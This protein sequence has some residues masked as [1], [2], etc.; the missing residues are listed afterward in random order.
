MRA[1]QV[2]LLEFS[3]SLTLSR[4][5]LHGLWSSKSLSGSDNHDLRE[6]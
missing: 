4:G 6:R 5:V 2:S 1:L 3:P